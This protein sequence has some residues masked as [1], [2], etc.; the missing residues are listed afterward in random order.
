IPSAARE[1]YCYRTAC[2]KITLNPC[3]PERRATKIMFCYI[4]KG[5]ESKD[6]ENISISNAASGSSPEKYFCDL[7]LSCGPLIRQYLPMPNS[8]SSRLH[9]CETQLQDF[10]ASL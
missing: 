10:L 4:L 6:P 5:A 7:R 9:R 3:L 2:H 8:N 1:P